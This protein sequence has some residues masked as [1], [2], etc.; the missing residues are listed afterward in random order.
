MEIKISKWDLIKHKYPFCL[1]ELKT[2]CTAKES[3]S[4][5]KRQP[6]KWEKIFTNDVTSKGLV[7]KIYSLCSFISSEQQPNQKR[8]R[9]PKQ[10]FPQRRPTDAKEAQEKMFNL[11]DYKRNAKS[12]N[13]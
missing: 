2:F 8:S 7:S 6:T 11:T 9:R 1:F 3:I 4:K 12:H 10:T 5:M 13:E